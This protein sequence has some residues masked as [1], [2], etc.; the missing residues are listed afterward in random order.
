MIGESHMAH[1]GMREKY[2]RQQA[3]K[4]S[5]HRNQQNRPGRRTCLCQGADEL[6]EAMGRRDRVGQRN[7][8]T[9]PNSDSPAVQHLRLG[10]QGLV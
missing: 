3:E 10:E 8:E 9:G 2:G 6:R 5:L 4:Q 1:E 7:K